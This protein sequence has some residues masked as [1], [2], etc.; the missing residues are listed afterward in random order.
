MEISVICTLVGQQL[1]ALL[2]SLLIEALTVV[3]VGYCWL[4]M[5]YTLATIAI[6]ATLMTHPFVWLLFAMG[7]GDLNYELRLVLIELMVVGVE[8][9]A[10]HWVTRYS[11]SRSVILSLMTNSASLL[12]GKLIFQ[13]FR[14]Q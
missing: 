8:A 5:P 2:T 14:C 13:V 4:G 7:K 9:V 3:I 10:F 11:L 6:A 1:G 12:F